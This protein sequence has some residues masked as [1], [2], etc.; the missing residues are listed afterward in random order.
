MTKRELAIRI[1][2]RE[3]A[4][5]V[6]RDFLDKYIKESSEKLGWNKVIVIEQAETSRY[7][8]NAIIGRTALNI[9][10]TLEEII[11]RTN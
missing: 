3:R 4:A 7:I 11:L 2:E 6:A 1:N 10:E 9:D 8:M 5:K